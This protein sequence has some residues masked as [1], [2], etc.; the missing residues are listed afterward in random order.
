MFEVVELKLYYFVLFVNKVQRVTGTTLFR[1]R[2]TTVTTIRSVKSLEESVLFAT[3]G[4][5]LYQEHI[6]DAETR[7]KHHFPN[8]F[9]ST[10]DTVQL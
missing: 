3:E 1:S 4:Y 7:Q 9:D 10:C 5:Y 6:M 2:V 8:R